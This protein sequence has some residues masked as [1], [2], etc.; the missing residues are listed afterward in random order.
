MPNAESRVAASLG[1]RV[2]TALWVMLTA[3]C[4]DLPFRYGD[5]PLR[6]RLQLLTIFIVLVVLLLQ[7]TARGR[8]PAEVFGWAGVAALTGAGVV[9]APLGP[10]HPYQSFVTMAVGMSAAALLPWGLRGQAVIVV[11]LWSTDFWRLVAPPGPP[12][13]TEVREFAILTFALAVSIYA[14]W[15]LAR[16]R[17][18]VDG[19]HRE[20]ERELQRHQDFLRQVLDI[21]PHLVFAKDRNGRFTLANR[22]VAE[23]Y[24]TRVADLIGKTDADFNPESGEVEQFRSDDLAV[25]EQR[26]ERII[27]IEKITDARGRERWL[28]TIKRPLPTDDGG[29]Q[30]LGIATDITEQRLT[31]Q[32]LEE[33]ARIA[34]ALAQIGREIMSAFNLPSLLDHLCG[35]SARTLEG[36]AAQLWIFDYEHDCYLP[37]GRYGIDDEDWEAMKVLRI[38]LG[39]VDTLIRR[40]SQFDVVVLSRPQAVEIVGRRLVGAQ[41]FDHLI[42]MT[43]RDRGQALGTLLV[44]FGPGTFPRPGAS[45]IAHG[46]AQ[47]SSLAMQNHQLVDEL[48]RANKLKS[49]FV[50]TMSHELRT[51]LNVIIGYGDLLLD[52]AM[53]EITEEQ[54]DTLRRM[55]ANAWELLELINAT[56]DLSRLEAGQVDLDIQPTDL[57]AL[58][59]DFSRSAADRAKP[60]VAFASAYAGG[61]PI[62]RTDPG[63]LKV[64]LKNLVSNAFKFTER[65]TVRVEI[66]PDGD[67]HH[68]LLRVSDTGIGITPDQQ[69]IIFDAFR[70]ADG[71]ISR[72]F[73]G[74]GLG[75]HIVQRLSELLGGE[76][77]VD[78][79]L[80]Q[81]ATFTVRLP[82]D[83]TGPASDAGR[84]PA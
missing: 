18:A 12:T 2:R 7:R 79:A 61:L 54:R 39:E 4:A 8:I 49:E 32:R 50:A 5:W 51:P 19:A 66:S 35:L 3:V 24:G 27:A 33:E 34:N 25:L 82:C 65:G 62:V 15:E 36:A 45:R 29:F 57:A 46:I 17:T 26:V 1:A 58:L 40:I 22:A 21:N 14:A 56:L 73:G 71:S 52:G 69:K 55:Q 37:R 28:S 83:S 67:D 6:D 30:V 70:Q 74:V 76:V 16:T 80:G 11:I 53:G 81:G 48:G 63:K 60:G 44:T 10:P 41:D 59:D 84:S 77:A 78:S 13:E 64:I 9:L 75:L 31:Q 42:V 20:R 72:K 23:V 47:L 38:P 43:I 68:F